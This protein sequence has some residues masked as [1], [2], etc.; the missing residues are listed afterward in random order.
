[1][2]SQIFAKLDYYFYTYIRSLGSRKWIFIFSWLFHMLE[3]S[4]MGKNFSRLSALIR[5][6]FDCY[7]YIEY[8]VEDDL[9]DLMV[10]WKVEK[11]I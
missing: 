3:V 6:T 5:F 10:K 7:T 1:M 2:L 8:V 4:S 9:R 11:T